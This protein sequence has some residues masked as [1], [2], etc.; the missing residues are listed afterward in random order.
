MDRTIDG[1][2]FRMLTVLDEYSRECLATDVERKLKADDVL[3]RLGK[4]FMKR[5]VPEYIRSACYE[6]VV[7]S[8]GFGRSV[9]SPIEQKFRVASLGVTHR[10]SSG[11]KPREQRMPSA[12]RRAF[13]I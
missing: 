10:A 8:F 7:K 11:H 9:G 5:G 13:P 2:P 1:R 12:K 6:Q 4:Q 3:Y